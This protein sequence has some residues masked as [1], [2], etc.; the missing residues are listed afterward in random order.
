MIIQSYPDSTLVPR[1]ATKTCLHHRVRELNS[2]ELNGY[3]TLRDVPSTFL[4]TDVNSSLTRTINAVPTSYE[5]NA[6]NERGE[7]CRIMMYLLTPENYIVVSL[8]WT[9]FEGIENLPFP[10]KAIQR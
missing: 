10:D 1:H 6:S 2:N 5:A 3:I 7:C 4:I 8:V 9:F